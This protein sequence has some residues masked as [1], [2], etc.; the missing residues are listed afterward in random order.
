MNRRKSNWRRLTVPVVSAGLIGLG[1]CATGSVRPVVLRIAKSRCS[2]R[3]S[4]RA[5]RPACHQPGLCR[6]PD[7][8]RRRSTKGTFEHRKLEL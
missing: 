7:G 3:Y 2:N 4:V 5:K 8:Q 1:A 6:R